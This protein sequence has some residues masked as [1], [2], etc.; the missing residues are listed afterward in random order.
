MCSWALTKGG[1]KSRTTLESFSAVGHSELS[2]LRVGTEKLET[3]RLAARD[4]C[5]HTRKMLP[6][7]YNF[8]C[9]CL[10]ISIVKN[11]MLWWICCTHFYSLKRGDSMRVLLT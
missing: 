9:Q 7:L 4:T 8:S 6:S 5:L 1:H 2:F 11:G 10:K 3:T